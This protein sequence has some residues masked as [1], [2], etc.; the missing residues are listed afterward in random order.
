MCEI[1]DGWLRCVRCSKGYPVLRGIPHLYVYDE[2]WV[3][4]AREAQ[5]WVDFHKERGIYEQPEDAVDLKIPYYPEEPW[6]S[7]ARSFDIAL[8]ELH[9]ILRPGTTVLDLGAGRGWAAKHF[10]L[11][12]CQAVALDI[13]PDEN[14]GL[15]RAWALMK[16]ANVYFELVIA[17]GE[18]LPFFPGSFDLVFCAAALHHATDLSLLMRNIQRVLK[19]G[20]VLCAISEPCI[21]IDQSAERVLKRDAESELKH[22]I[23]EQRPN[24]LEYWIALIEAGF[25]EVRF[26]WPPGY[27]LSVSQLTDCAKDLGAIYPG[28]SKYGWRI[29]LR[30]WMLYL[31][32]QIVSLPKRHNLRALP[33]F[34]NDHQ[35]LMC[36]IL[37]WVSGEVII[38]AKTRECS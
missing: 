2:R 20:G 8:E 9:S 31:Y 38:L 12:G 33:M 21:A 18:R 28:W 25:S 15:G 36:D 22:G 1:E 3:L 23:N 26:I 14:V 24:L 19:P 13:N 35:Q 10:T 27:R 17:D 34:D 30:R 4:K 16:H 37:L 5:G 32:H 29:N 7:V 6:I 11:H